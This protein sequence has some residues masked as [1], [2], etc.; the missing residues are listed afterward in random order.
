MNLRQNLKYLLEMLPKTEII[1]WMSIWITLNQRRVIW[2]PPQPP[3]F[4][5][6]QLS[7]INPTSVF[8]SFTTVPVCTP[9]LGVDHP[10]VRSE[11]DLQGDKTNIR[12]YIQTGIC[13]CGGSDSHR[14]GRLQSRWTHHC[15]AEYPQPGLNWVEMAAAGS[16]KSKRKKRTAE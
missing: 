11:L 6:Q 10:S 15:P 16:E 12:N 2:T 3:N 8:L 1:H 7:G 4:W 5:L 13:N 9:P 14:W